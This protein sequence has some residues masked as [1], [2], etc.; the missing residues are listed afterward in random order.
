[1]SR[2]PKGKNAF[3]SL[4]IN[5]VAEEEIMKYNNNAIHL[6]YSAMDNNNLNNNRFP[7]RLN[8]TKFSNGS[9]DIN[10]MRNT[11]YQ[12]KNRNNSSNK[13]D[14]NNNT[15]EN[16]GYK[17]YP[18]KKNK[19]GIVINIYSRKN[20]NDK[21]DIIINEDNY[22]FDNENENQTEKDEYENLRNNK[23]NFKESDAVDIVRNMWI[24]N[25][26]IINETN[27]DIKNIPKNNLNNKIMKEV[28]FIIKPINKWENQLKKEIENFFTIYKTS[29]KDRFIY[30][31]YN[32]IKDLTNSIFLPK[33]NDNDLYITNPPNNFQN[34]NKIN[35][36]L[37]KPKD[38][39][40]LES[41]L[42]EYYSQ[43]KNNYCTNID[44]NSDIE[45]QKLRPIYVLNK[46]QIC[47]LYK[48]LNI[49]EEKVRNW[50]IDKN[51]LVIAR[52]VS[53]YCEVIEVF[54]PRNNK[55]NNTNRT[56]YNDNIYESNI[57]NENSI[58]NNSQDFGQ[59]TPYLC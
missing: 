29:S 38:R 8:Q 41:E 21:D 46:P 15:T 12:T 36:K 6:T 44:N 48:E 24:Q 28:N 11:N 17:V 25:N 54:T 49:K 10:V 9:S 16:S 4:R 34:I 52:Q 20:D 47:E 31:E 5:R 58:K 1:M 59:Y 30:N 43:N 26:K 18:I 40:Q 33:N 27:I 7:K 45:E 35:Y 3:T 55:D 14:K 32:Y 50:G 23:N 22:C 53:I 42:F 56:K 2:K 19:S 13:K 51:E 39:N 57:R 37:I